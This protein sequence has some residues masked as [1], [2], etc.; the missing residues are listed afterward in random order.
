VDVPIS[1]VIEALNAHHE[2]GGL[3]KAVERAFKYDAPDNRVGV[4]VTASWSSDVVAM[5][6][7]SGA[8]A[9]CAGV[10]LSGPPFS[11][12]PNVGIRILLEY[13]EMRIRLLA[14]ASLL[15]LGASPS[16]AARSSTD[17]KIVTMALG[18]G[19]NAVFI[20]ASANPEG[21]SCHTHNYWHYIVSLDTVLGKN[22]YAM[23]LAA[24]AGGQSV[25]LSG[26]DVCNLWDGVESLRAVGVTY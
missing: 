21:T 22:M 19:G 20:R 9:T 15:L 8:N 2:L 25:S 4:P 18:T 26:A 3:A 23:L 7:A 12:R 10:N 6:A 17:V 11:V 14:V 5:T 1:N 16:Q 24:A 13:A